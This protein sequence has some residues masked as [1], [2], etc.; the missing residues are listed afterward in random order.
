MYLS[1][2]KQILKE[3]SEMQKL[4]QNGELHGIQE[5]EDPSQNRERLHEG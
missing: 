4:T 5:T 1:K 3:N 2:R